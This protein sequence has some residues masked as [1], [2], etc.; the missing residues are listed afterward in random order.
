[1]MGGA[2]PKARVL[3]CAD[4]AATSRLIERFDGWSHYANVLATDGLVLD[5][6]EDRTRA[7]PGWDCG[8]GV[9]VGANGKVPPGVRLRPRSY[10]DKVPRWIELELA[11][12]SAEQY[13]AWERAGRAQLGKPYDKLG[14]L[15]FAL[16]WDDR[17]NWRDQSAWFCDELGIFMCEQAKICRPIPSPIYKFTPGAALMLLLGDP[18]TR[19]V[20]SRG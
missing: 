10:L 5:A 11:S 2:V 18:E 4:N 14:I 19:I 15:G 6:R 17:R 9:I 1:M 8:E 7:P 3:L 13:Q 12:R 16:G 20:A